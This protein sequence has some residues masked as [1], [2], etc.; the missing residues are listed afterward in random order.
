[1]RDDPSAE[2]LLERLDAIEV[3]LDPQPH[4]RGR[5]MADL[6]TV[7][8]IVVLAVFFDWRI[9]HPLLLLVLLLSATGLNRLIPLLTRRALLRE[10]DRITARYESIASQESGGGTSIGRSGR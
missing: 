4:R 2:F 5:L 9:T 3:R 1:V 6:L 7:G 8:V 10:R